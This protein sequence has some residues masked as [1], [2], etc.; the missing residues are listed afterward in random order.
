MDFDLPL[1]DYDR[2]NRAAHG[3]IANYGQDALAEAVKRA[4]TMRSAGF[5]G[6]AAAWDFICEIIRHRVGGN[7]LA[8]CAVASNLPKPE[9]SQRVVTKFSFFDTP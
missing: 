6:S 9:M 7:A 8:G 2:L 3:M 1:L 4:R 5:D